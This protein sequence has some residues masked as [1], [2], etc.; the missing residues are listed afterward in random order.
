LQLF[1]DPPAYDCEEKPGR[2]PAHENA[3]QCLKRCEHP[4]RL[5]QHEIAVAGGRV[6]G[7]GKIE[8]ILE[9]GQAAPPEIEQPPYENLDRV[10]Q[11]Q[12]AP[13][14]DQKP[15]HVPEARRSPG[16]QPNQGPE[17]R[18]EPDGMYDHGAH[19]QATSVENYSEY[20]RQVRHSLFASGCALQRGESLP[21]IKPGHSL[22]L[23]AEHQAIKLRT[24]RVGEEMFRRLP[25]ISIVVLRTQS[26]LQPLGKAI[27]AA[28]SEL[29]VLLR[30][31][32]LTI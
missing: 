22:K 29:S 12:P 14:A 26:C 4:P 32:Y 19:Y 6:G 13:Q 15:D 5:G 7:P 11:N 10:D 31:L 17:Q 20:L 1:A 25:L 8:R 3:S 21:L 2:D 30:L 9:I 18:A 27:E 24:P 23:N 28:N 16:V